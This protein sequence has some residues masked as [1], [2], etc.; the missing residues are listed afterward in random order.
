MKKWIIRIFILIVI[1]AIWMDGYNDKQVASEAIDQLTSELVSYKTKYNQLVESKES[2]LLERDN[3]KFVNDSLKDIISHF[4]E[5][6]SVIEYKW[7]LKTDT[8]EVPIPIFIGGNDSVFY[9]FEHDDGYNLVSGSVSKS[10]IKI[11]PIE[12]NNELSIVSGYKK[13]GFLKR[14]KHFIDISNSNPYIITSGVTNFHVPH[15]KSWHERWFIS[16]AIGI[17]GGVLIS[18]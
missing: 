8:I 17:I 15:K 1:V 7:R 5:P 3:F 11:N 10:R 4:K 14:K 9:D 2:V 13:Q 18:R 6:E 16:G 12:V